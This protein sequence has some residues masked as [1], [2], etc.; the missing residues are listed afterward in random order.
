MIIIVEGQDKNWA[1]V[2]EALLDNPKRI[3][4]SS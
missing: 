4:W 1:I 3:N 2:V